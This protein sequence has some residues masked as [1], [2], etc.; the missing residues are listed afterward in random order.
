MASPA[1]ACSGGDVCASYCTLQIK[2]CGS[3]EAPL[4]GD[5]KD[6][7]GN[8]LYQYPDMESCIANCA[9]L[10]KTHAYRTDAA[11]NSLACR[12]LHATRAAKDLESAKAECAY[13]GFIEAGPCQ[14]APTP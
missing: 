13:S 7:N 8:P 2:A 11:G 12:L 4:P 5:P 6:T 10:D 9:A 14:G 3:Q 1:A